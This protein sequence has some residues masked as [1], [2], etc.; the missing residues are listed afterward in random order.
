M[1]SVRR[2]AVDRMHSA[3]IHLLRRVRETDA[4]AMGIS[5]A[6]ASALSVLVFGGARS[7]TE[8][9]AAEQ[10]T[11][12][13]MSKLVTAMEAE[14]L[15]RRYPDV[16]DARSIRIEATAKARRILERGRM[17]RLDLLEQLLSEASDR[18]IE[19]VR[20]AAEAVERALHA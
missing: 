3:A 6:R 11:S 17:R 12:A 2:E 9:A 19:S 16:N 5:P 18:E 14:G 4:S 7:L 10:V 20:V 13:T 8:L 15:V 1:S